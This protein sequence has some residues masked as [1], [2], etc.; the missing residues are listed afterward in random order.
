MAGRNKHLALGLHKRA[1][2]VA[3][4]SPRSDQELEGARKQLAGPAGPGAGRQP[5]GG[6]QPERYSG[7]GSRL[8]SRLELLLLRR[9]AQMGAQFAVSARRANISAEIGRSARGRQ[10]IVCGGGGPE[11]KLKNS[12]ARGTRE[13]FKFASERNT[14]R[15]VLCSQTRAESL[16]PPPERAR[17]EEEE[18]EVL[19][20]VFAC[21]AWRE[22]VIVDILPLA[23]TSGR[24]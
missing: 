24:R 22:D 2:G 14:V 10:P 7:P 1:L 17:Q 8:G 21:R 5:P 3:F 12:A 20:S 11:R 6:A 18:E 23:G 13:K 19:V 15:E 9:P 16:G 4:A